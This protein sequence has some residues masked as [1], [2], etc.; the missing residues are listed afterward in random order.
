VVVAGVATLGLL[1]GACGSG[2][3]TNSPAD[4]AFLQT[5][6]LTDPEINTYRTDMQLT[7]LGHAV[8]DDFS[9]G[10]SYQ[11][12]ADRLSTL[13]GSNKL[14]SSDLGSVIDSAVAAMCPQYRTQTS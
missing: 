3:A 12:V 2:S 7:R 9:S 10:A 8:C 13:Q 1:V 4:Q 6:H 11:E 5:L 14:P